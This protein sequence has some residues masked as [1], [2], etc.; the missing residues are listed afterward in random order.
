[1]EVGDVSDDHGV[2]LHL[3]VT[4]DQSK[5]VNAKGR[6]IIPSGGPR[7]SCGQTAIDICVNQAK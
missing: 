7:L 5:G 1:M 3:V 2:P 4:L 6:T